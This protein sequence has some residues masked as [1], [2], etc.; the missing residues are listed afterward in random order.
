MRPGVIKDYIIL[1]IIF[2]LFF[3]SINAEISGEAPATFGYVF[4]AI[5]FL[6]GFMALRRH[7]SKY[8][9]TMLTVGLTVQLVFALAIPYWMFNTSMGL[10][11]AWPYFPEVLWDTGRVAIWFY[12]ISFLFLPLVVYFFGRRAWCSFICGTGVLSETVGDKYRIYGSKGSGIPGYFIAIKWLILAGTIALTV[13]M[14][15][16]NSQS[17]M[18]NLIFLFFF[19]LFLRTFILNFVNLVFMP[20]LGT[21]IWCKYFCPQGLLL[22]LISRLGR[23][24]LVRDDNLCAGCGTCN[25]HCHMSIDITSGPG[26]NRSGDCVGCGVCVEVCPHQALSMTTDQSLLRE[27][28]EKVR[29]PG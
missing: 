23:F 3:V 10:N 27:K 6:A 25:K 24:A 18:L 13:M 7:E 26:V 4:V 17:Q 14:L 20:K 5:V 28:E 2:L 12:I 21:R 15:T 19:I 8:F 9:K 16:G 22:G 29:L 11:V 1:T